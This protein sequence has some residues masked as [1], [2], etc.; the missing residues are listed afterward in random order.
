MCQVT[1]LK[2]VGRVG[3]HIFFYY[4][5]FLEKNIILC[6]LPFKMHKSYIFPENL[7]KVYVSLGSL[8]RVGLP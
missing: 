7:K 1:G 6:I 2:I 4:F 5:F 3:T 8:G